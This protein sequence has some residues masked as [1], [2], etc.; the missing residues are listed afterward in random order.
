[1]KILVTG[2]R[3]Y[4]VGPSDPNSPDFNSP[5]E[6][7]QRRALAAYQRSRVRIVLDALHQVNPITCVV[8]GGAKGADSLA[9]EWAKHNQIEVRT[10]NADW[11]RFKASA[12]P[13]R[14]RE[15]IDKESPHLV[16]AFPGGSGTR[17]CVRYA[18]ERHVSVLEVEP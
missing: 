5:A 16:V 18:R 11:S 3:T 9:Y 7:E 2:G 6:Y 13:I 8:Q 17:Q 10:Y 4:G 12:G 15:M 14:N 1:M